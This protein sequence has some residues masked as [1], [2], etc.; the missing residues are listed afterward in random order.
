M[1][2]RL[3]ARISQ[4]VGEVLGVEIGDTLALHKPKGAFASVKRL[5]HSSL[6]SV[7]RPLES[8]I[9]HTVSLLTPPSQPQ[10]PPFPD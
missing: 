5:V 3:G 1:A 7:H 4:D 9:Q 6:D 10:R 8:S 2:E